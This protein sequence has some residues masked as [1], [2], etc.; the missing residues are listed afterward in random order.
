MASGLLNYD[1][2]TGAVRES[3]ADVRKKQ[4]LAPSSVPLEITKQ[5]EFDRLLLLALDQFLAQKQVPELFLKSNYFTWRAHLQQVYQENTLG[6][7]GKLEQAR[8][9][10]EG[11]IWSDYK[12]LVNETNRIYLSRYPFVEVALRGLQLTKAMKDFSAFEGKLHTLHNLSL[13][14]PGS[15][16]KFGGVEELT[17]TYA[18]AQEAKAINVDHFMIGLQQVMSSDRHFVVSVLKNGSRTHAKVTAIL[19]G[20]SL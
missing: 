6:F 15:A 18:R 16:A 7:R 13:A 20:N 8:R 14:V 12:T 2:T 11:Q 1:N 5:N 9:E 4:Q 19:K 17:Q 10:L 3:I